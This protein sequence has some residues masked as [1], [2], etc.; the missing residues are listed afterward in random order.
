MCTDKTASS[1]RCYNE[2]DEYP[3]S[4]AAHLPILHMSNMVILIK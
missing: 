2:N 4:V 3:L 1:E